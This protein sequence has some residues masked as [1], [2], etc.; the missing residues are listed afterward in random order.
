VKEAVLVY[1]SYHSTTVLT[2]CKEKKC[3]IL[4]HLYGKIAVSIGDSSYTWPTDVL[5]IL[6]TG[7]SINVI[8]AVL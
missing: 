7:L 6:D 2:W 8:T 4:L 5:P 3:Y 1:A